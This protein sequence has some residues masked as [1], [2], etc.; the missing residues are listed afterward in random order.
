MMSKSLLMF[1]VIAHLLT[2]YDYYYVHVLYFR[3]KKTK[4]KTKL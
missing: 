3:E 1:D 4:R 2:L